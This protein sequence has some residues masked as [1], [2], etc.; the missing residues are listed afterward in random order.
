[1]ATKAPAKPETPGAQKIT[2]TEFCRRASLRDE[3]KK[4]PE[5]LGAF[6]A[7]ERAARRLKDTEAAYANRL[8]E[9]MKK[10]M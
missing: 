7:V 3:Y 10:P 4:R 9:L 2:V 6:H 8:A 5:L 1:M